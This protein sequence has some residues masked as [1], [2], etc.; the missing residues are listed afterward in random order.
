MTPEQLQ[1]HYF[2]MHDLDK[3]NALDGLELCKAITHWHGD[4]PATAPPKI[5]DN[6]L[7]DMIDSILR[8]D[9]F[10]NDGFIDYPEF[11]RSQAARAADAPP[12]PPAPQHA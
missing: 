8:D 9:D 2:N 12:A 6:E 4:D 10:N 7:E 1:F 11:L 5:E 3:S